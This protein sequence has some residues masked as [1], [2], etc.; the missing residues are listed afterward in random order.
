[1]KRVN[2]IERSIFVMLAAFVV[3][4]G[5]A[6]LGVQTP[7]T[8]EERVAAG[9]ATIEAVA[10]TAGSL[11]DAGKITVDDAKNVVEHT[12]VAHAGL[13][14]AE[15]VRAT[16]PTAAENRLVAIITALSAINDYLLC[17][18]TPATCSSP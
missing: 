5:C 16:D 10:D 6:A 9:Y 11:L 4:A 7:K 3:L 18:E 8:F 1:M 14:I 12:R 2:S 13:V 17:K 15:Q